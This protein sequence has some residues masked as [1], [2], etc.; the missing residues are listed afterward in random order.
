MA[1]NLLTGLSFAAAGG[2]ALVGGVFFGFSSFIMAGLGRLAPEQGASAMNSINVT[3]INPAFMT[4][5]FG[6]GL[7]CLIA[8]AMALGS[9][10]SLDGKLILAAAL[11]YV[12]GCDG[13]T[14]ALNVP[15]NNALARAPVGTPEGAALW[16][17]YLKDWTFWN[18]VRTAASFAAAILFVA[19]G[20]C[21]AA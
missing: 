14:M 13:V 15:L 1:D 12:I 9:P 21:R 5:L 19:A 10:G 18:S 20:V 11:L 8:A 3:V 17:R 2:A 4:A 6:T 7:L 16:A